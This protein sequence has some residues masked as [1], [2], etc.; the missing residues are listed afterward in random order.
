MP[1]R[2]EFVISE[3]SVLSWGASVQRA[4]LFRN[5]QQNRLVFHWPAGSWKS[6]IELTL[7]RAIVDIY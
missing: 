4:N 2:Q 3:L 5:W 1:S 7:N 6:M